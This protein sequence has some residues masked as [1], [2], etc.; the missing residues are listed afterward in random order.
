VL[1]ERREIV[2]QRAGDDVLVYA[3]GESAR[4]ER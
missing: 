4:H 2:C 3:I 1:V